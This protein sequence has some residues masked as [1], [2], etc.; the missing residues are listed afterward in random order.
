MNELVPV[1]KSGEYLEVHETSLK[2]HQQ[3]GWSV[4][5]KR[6]PVDHKDAYYGAIHGDDGSELSTRKQRAKKSDDK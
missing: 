1:S 2:Q 3:L 5:A 6:A 4:C